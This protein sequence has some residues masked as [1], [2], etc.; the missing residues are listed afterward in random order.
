MGSR[1]AG[2]DCKPL[3][4]SPWRVQVLGEPPFPFHQHVFQE[5]TQVQPRLHRRESLGR[6]TAPAARDES[7]HVLRDAGV[8]L[9]QPVVLHHPEEH[10]GV[11]ERG[12]GD[13]KVEQLPGECAQRVDVAREARPLASQTL[14]CCVLH[15]VRH[16]S[17]MRPRPLK[18][19]DG[20]GPQ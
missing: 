11:R 9:R 17:I 5:L 18:L 12:I 14:W 6:I 1:G 8:Q 19:R 15:K 4:M 7:A 20:P 13:V 10:D 16:V 3:V 2:Q